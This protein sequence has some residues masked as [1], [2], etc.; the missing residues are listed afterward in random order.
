[1][2]EG[3]LG[4]ANFGALLALLTWPSIP[5]PSLV[6]PEVNAVEKTSPILE[7]SLE[8]ALT[9]LDTC[10]STSPAVC[11]PCTLPP[12]RTL[13]LWDLNLFWL[14]FAVGISLVLVVYLCYRAFR[15]FVS[16][17]LQSLGV[18]PLGQPQRAGAN[19]Q[20]V[21]EPANRHMLLALGLQR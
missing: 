13:A 4:L 5:C 9:S 12:S 16:S 20:Q 11:P 15:V 17:V 1:M 8:F 18:P 2:V 14:G 7:R 6:C 19:P 10:K 3:I 21:I